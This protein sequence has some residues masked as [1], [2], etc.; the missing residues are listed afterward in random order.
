MIAQD[1]NGLVGGA[2][3]PHDLAPHDLASLALAYRSSLVG[4]EEFADLVGAGSPAAIRMRRDRDPTFPAPVRTGTSRP[5]YGFGLLH[6]WLIGLPARNQALA[7]A[8]DPWRL[9]R[10]ALE[11]SAQR[12]ASRVDADTAFHVV[13]AL[14]LRLAAG[15]RPDASPTA[16]PL[17][18][19]VRAPAPP[20]ADPWRDALLPPGFLPD[21]PPATDPG[22]MGRLLDGVAVGLP[23]GEQLATEVT[24]AWIHRPRAPAADA[25]VA[26]V[27]DVVGRL[28]SRS[29]K[30]RPAT[31]A[32]AT[33]L[34]VELADLAPGQIV[35]DPAVGEANLLLRADAATR[36]ARLDAQVLGLVGRD[37]DERAWLVAK[38]RLGLRGVAHQLGEPGCDST[39]PAQLA[40]AYDRILAEPDVG[41]RA[42]RPWLEQLPRLLT[43]DGIGVVTVPE[44]QLVRAGGAGRRWW[45][46]FQRHVAAVVIA[47][48]LHARRSIGAFVLRRDHD[49]PV[50]LVQID[51][52]PGHLLDP[53]TT[54]ED[55][56]L[57]RFAIAGELLRRHLRG[58]DL[59]DGGRDGVA[60]RPITELSVDALRPV[61][62]GDSAPV[63]SAVERAPT[64]R[65]A[66]DRA[67]AD[68]LRLTQQLRLYVDST[69]ALDPGGL[70]LTEEIR[71]VLEEEVT[72]EVRRA[73]KRLEQRLAG[74]ET[75][76]RP[77][78]SPP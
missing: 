29:A 75:R 37:L 9:Q 34:L 12:C 27:E 41:T 78:R 36:G 72:E 32:V 30:Q 70:G 10:W 65:Q 13:A 1:N 74:K 76:G 55:A 49:G 33:E 69:A 26:V 21:L 52:V 25:F 40:G 67:T 61:R 63:R 60:Y 68:A 44:Q 18:D 53:G 46:D 16:A 51:R 15:W 56:L 59:G 28:A 48:A 14:A 38:V 24:R 19:Q 54:P 31:G 62:W 66:R 71:G 42:V 58:T 22:V 5:E 2:Q 73:L 64:A 17:L 3:A 23:A 4:L 11:Q 6:D 20:P 45:D 39:D 47:P 8:P 35:L 43:A 57:R 7:V 77:R 50:L